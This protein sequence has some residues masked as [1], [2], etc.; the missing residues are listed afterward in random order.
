MVKCQ[1]MGK[2][3][4]NINQQIYFGLI[5]TILK[6]ILTLLKK[7]YREKEK[8]KITR[9]RIRAHD[10]GMNEQEFCVLPITLQSTKMSIASIVT[11]IRS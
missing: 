5:Y 7:R 9:S 1:H 10:P 4:C 11:D 2:C 8:K 6:N 3:R